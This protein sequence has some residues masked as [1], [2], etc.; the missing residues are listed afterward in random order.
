MKA[1]GKFVDGVPVGQHALYGVGWDSKMEQPVSCIQETVNYD[2]Q[3]QLHGTCIF[4]NDYCT[5]SQVLNFKHGVLHGRQLMFAFIN[6]WAEVAYQLPEVAFHMKDGVLHGCVETTDARGEIHRRHVQPDDG[7]TL[8][9]IVGER[10]LRLPSVRSVRGFE[11]QYVSA[12]GAVYSCESKALGLDTGCI[13]DECYT[14][15]DMENDYEDDDYEIGSCY[16]DEDC[17]DWRER[18]QE[19]QEWREWDYRQRHW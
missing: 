15:E 19:E 5:K 11:S 4:N 1:Y 13:C 6:R 10:A 2:A 12:T 9:D 8:R 17:Y 3:G 16:N 14:H 7:A 18:R